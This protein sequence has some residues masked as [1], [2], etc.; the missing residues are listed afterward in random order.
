MQDDLRHM[1]LTPGAVHVLVAYPKGLTGRLIVEALSHTRE[2]RVA[3]HVSSSDAVIAFTKH[4]QIHIALI[5][6]N[7]AE[8]RD[9]LDILR[10]LR[11]ENSEIRTVMLME[12]SDPHLVVESFRF[13]AKGV[14]PMSTSGYELMCKCIQAVY[15]G[16]IWANAQELNWVMDCLRDVTYNV[17]AGIA[18]KTPKIL[19]FDRLSKRE[20]D[21]VN[22]LAEG[23]SNRDIARMLSL[24]ENTIKNYLF[25]IFEKV[26][27]SNRTEL[28]LQ[29]FRSPSRGVAVVRKSKVGEK[30]GHASA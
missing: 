19:D 12:N 2:F 25:R 5:A 18:V 1:A 20:A 3:A 16:Q 4:A 24:S 8:P 28:L 6:V 10:R 11:A 26:G 15:D 27:V 7:L 29:A 17:A 13:G 14:F 22:L 30:A 23:L 21:V 9:G